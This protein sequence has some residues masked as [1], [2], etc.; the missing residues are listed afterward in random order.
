MLELTLGHHHPIFLSTNCPAK[1][2]FIAWFGFLSFSDW[3]CTSSW[4]S[5]VRPVIKWTTARI[6]LRQSV[7]LIPARHCMFSPSLSM[8]YSPSRCRLPRFRSFQSSYAITWYGGKYAPNVNKCLSHRGLT[9]AWAFFW[10]AF[11]PWILVI[12]FQTMVP[13]LLWCWF[14]KGWLNIIVNWGSLLFASLANFVIP[15]LLYFASRR[16]RRIRLPDNAEGH[17]L[18]IV[19]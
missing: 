8:F 4:A 13:R 5:S 1:Y 11:F 19:N 9:L 17:H 7:L 10:A 18:A 15:F 14:R 12:P 6:F 2:P 3:V 16:H